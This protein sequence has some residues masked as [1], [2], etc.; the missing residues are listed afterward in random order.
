MIDVIQ[1]E[2]VIEDFSRS[3][4][5]KVFGEAFIKHVNES[6]PRELTVHEKQHVLFFTCGF[7]RFVLRK[8]GIV[9]DSFVEFSESDWEMFQDECDEMR[10]TVKESGASVVLEDQILKENLAWLHFGSEIKSV[11]QKHHHCLFHL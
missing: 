10:S 9:I 7:T 2:D 1:F 5:I 6:L 3:L 4:L 11:K 8:D